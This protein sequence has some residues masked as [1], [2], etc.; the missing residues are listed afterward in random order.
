VRREVLDFFNQ[1][2]KSQT[3]AGLQSSAPAKPRGRRFKP[4]GAPTG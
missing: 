3:K 2:L 1:H 4:T